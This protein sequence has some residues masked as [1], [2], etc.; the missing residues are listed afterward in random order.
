[1]IKIDGRSPVKQYFEGNYSL[2][3]KVLNDEKINGCTQFNLIIYNR[4]KDKAEVLYKLANSFNL[5]HQKSELFLINVNQEKPYL[6]LFE[7]RFNN[8]FS[9][10]LRS[11]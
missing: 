11:P 4:I 1:M 7:Q 3:L 8:E 5:I 9:M 6:C 2:G 10:K